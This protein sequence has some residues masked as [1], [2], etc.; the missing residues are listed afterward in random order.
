MSAILR[1]KKMPKS[2]IYCP[3]QYD[4]IR[5]EVIEDSEEASFSNALENGIN[6]WV[7]RLNSCP[8]EDNTTEVLYKVVD[9]YWGIARERCCWCGNGNIIIGSKY[10]NE[11]GRKIVR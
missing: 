5:C 7:T 11:C 10:C 6:P 9:E 1:L 4:S 3:C 2:C 8:L